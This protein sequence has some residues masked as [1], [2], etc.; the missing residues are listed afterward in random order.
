MHKS[1]NIVIGVMKMRNI[2]SR[3][4]IKPTSL[5]QCVTNT[6]CRLPD[7]TTIPTLTY[8][9]SSLPQRSVQTITLISRE[10]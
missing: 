8:L 1:L 10:L 2:V 3:V 7:V 6:Q 5:S 9:C 4:G